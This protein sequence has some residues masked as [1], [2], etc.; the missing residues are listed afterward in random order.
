MY[1]HILGVHRKNQQRTY[2]MMLMQ[3]FFFLG[4][5][6][7]IVCVFFSDFLIKAYVVGTHL[8]C[9]CNSNGYP[10]HMPL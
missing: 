2:L 4:G 10:Q 3:C 6:E 9:R 8:N 5:G 1:L 7:V